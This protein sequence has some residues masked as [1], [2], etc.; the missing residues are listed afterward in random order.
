MSQRTWTCVYRPCCEQA[1]PYTRW[2]DAETEMQRHAVTDPHPT[3]DEA[4]GRW[5]LTFRLDNGSGLPSVH[6]ISAVSQP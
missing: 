5:P 3:P 6:Y 1:H 2:E 4:Q